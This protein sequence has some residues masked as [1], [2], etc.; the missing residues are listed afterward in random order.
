MIIS[1]VKYTSKEVIGRCLFLSLQLTLSF[2]TA[3]LRRAITTLWKA[4]KDVLRP[5]HTGRHIY[6]QSPRLLLG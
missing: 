3:G 6:I 1:F 4:Q 5:A 2:Q